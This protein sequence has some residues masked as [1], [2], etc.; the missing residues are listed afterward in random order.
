MSTFFW[1][2]TTALC[3]YFEL[4]TRS[5]ST[6]LSL[7]TGNSQS[8]S[9]W[10]KRIRSLIQGNEVVEAAFNLFRRNFF[11]LQVLSSGHEGGA[12]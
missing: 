4:L 7:D 1:G 8:Q 2:G 12:P 11:H 6:L 9:K 10:R 5:V 3:D